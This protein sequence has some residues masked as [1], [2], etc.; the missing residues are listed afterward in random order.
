MCEGRRQYNKRRYKLIAAKLKLIMYFMFLIDI[1]I[2]SIIFLK[3]KNKI[4]HYNL[5]IKAIINYKPLREKIIKVLLAA[6]KP[7]IYYKSHTILIFDI[8]LN[9]KN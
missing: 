1:E 4:L 7:T 6:C 5:Q 2:K 9:K 3:L 8:I